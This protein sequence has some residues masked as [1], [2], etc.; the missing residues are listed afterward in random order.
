MT[1]TSILMFSFLIVCF[2]TFTKFNRFVQKLITNMIKFVLYTLCLR[3]FIENHFQ[4]VISFAMEMKTI[5]KVDENYWS[6]VK[7]LS[8]ILFCTLVLIWITILVYLNL[9][10]KSAQNPM[11]KLNS[12]IFGFNQN[13]T[14]YFTLYYLNFFTIWLLIGVLVFC[15]D[16]VESVYLWIFFICYQLISSCINILKLLDDYSI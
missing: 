10:F 16:K 12:V 11:S 2:W 6:L 15:T 3:Y 14:V 8:I 9:N 13:S 7:T 4:F 5:N 1:L